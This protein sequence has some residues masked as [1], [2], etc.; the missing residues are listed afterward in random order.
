MTFFS[1]KPIPALDYWCKEFDW[2]HCGYHSY[3]AW[4]VAAIS[5]H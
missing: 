4:L 2:Q 3:K 1:V 5:L